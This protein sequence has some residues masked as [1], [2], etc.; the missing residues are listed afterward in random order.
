[1]AKFLPNQSFMLTIMIILPALRVH[2][3]NQSLWL[4]LTDY[5]LRIGYIC[6]ILLHT[7][8]VSETKSSIPIE[9]SIS[10]ILTENVRSKI[11]LSEDNHTSK[12]VEIWLEQK[13]KTSTTFFESTEGKNRKKE[14]QMSW[15][16]FDR[17]KLMCAFSLNH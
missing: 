12:C 15:Q 10:K 8:L 13:T 5:Q 7:L 2:L 3:I 4:I 6:L 14:Q 1:M 9:P 16:T 11:K 17:R